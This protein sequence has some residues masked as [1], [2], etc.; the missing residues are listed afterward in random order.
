MTGTALMEMEAELFTEDSG[1]VIPTAED[2][3]RQFSMESYDTRERDI[4]MASRIAGRNDRM[5]IGFQTGKEKGFLSRWRDYNREVREKYPWVNWKELK[6]IWKVPAKYYGHQILKNINIPRTN[7][8]NDILGTV[9]DT[10]Q[11]QWEMGYKADGLRIFP[12]IRV[13]TTFSEGATKL[14]HLY[15]YEHK[16]KDVPVFLSTGK[17]PD[18]AKLQENV[19]YVIATGD[20][21]Y[22]KMGDQKDPFQAAKGRNYSPRDY[23][24][25]DFLRDCIDV[26]TRMDFSRHFKDESQRPERWIVKDETWMIA[27]D[28]V[29]DTAK[30]AALPAGLA[31]K[32][33]VYKNTVGKS[34]LFYNLGKLFMDDSPRSGKRWFEWEALNKLYDVQ[35]LIFAPVEAAFEKSGV[36]G[37]AMRHIADRRY[38]ATAK[39]WRGF[40][41]ANLAYSTN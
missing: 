21:P 30:E 34:G 7:T 35:D 27:H 2:L 24:N 37:P 18:P 23:H 6:N 20:S 29:R 28:N 12:R 38:K 39:S 15:T 4:R 11:V 17:D 32:I 9:L 25:S 19:D 22:D 3:E 33:K 16:G 36:M 13:E 31:G 41:D 10:Y 40:F 8:L 26:F 5:T 1:T 14:T